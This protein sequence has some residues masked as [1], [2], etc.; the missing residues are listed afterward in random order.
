MLGDEPKMEDEINL[1]D[2]IDV[3][4]RRR[5]LVFWSVVL[6]A[7]ASILV[8][9]IMKPVYSGKTQLLIRVSGSSGASQ[10]AGLAS[11]MGVNLGGGGSSGGSISEI[12]ELIKTPAVE[13]R[14]YQMLKSHPS[15]E[16]KSIYDVGIG[17]LKTKMQGSI[18][19][20]SV[21]HENRFLAA[22]AADAY[23]Q[24]VGDYWN[25]LNIT[26]ARKK[27]EYL[28]K[29][30]PIAEAELKKA[31]DKLKRLTY[32]ISPSPT[33]VAGGNV[34]TIDITRLEREL[35]IQGAIYQMLRTEHANAKVQEAKEVSP[36]SDIEKA[37]IPGNPVIPNKKLNLVMGI[38]LGSFAGV[39]LAF[40][41]DYLKGPYQKK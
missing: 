34:K 22:A 38:V 13:R 26:E 12:D 29:Q 5:K 21:N 6:F 39:F 14:V 18:L 8:S 31:E 40:I 4:L 16:G 2:I 1:K 37:E 28:D 36:F 35:E 15:L 9:F 24:A 20:I 7:A 19:D 11:I 27:R 32:L 41:S 33:L 17:S 3:L 25:K 10:M 30:L 23:V